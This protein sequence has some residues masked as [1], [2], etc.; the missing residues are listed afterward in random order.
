MRKKK[1]KKNKDEEGAESISRIDQEPGFWE[2]TL[3]VV[4][5]TDNKSR[6]VT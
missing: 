4:N 1:K 3:K 5:V 6:Q 2:G